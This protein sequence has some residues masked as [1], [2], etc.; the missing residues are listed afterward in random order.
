MPTPPLRFDR[1]ARHAAALVGVGFAA[2][3]SI[4]SDFSEVVQA[5]N[6]AQPLPDDVPLL[7]FVQFATLLAF[8]LISFA[9][10]ATTPVR[11]AVT[12]TV[13][14]LLLLGWAFLGIERSSGVLPLGD[15]RI[16]GVLLDQGFVT[17]AVALAG[18]LIAR[19]MHPATWPILLLAVLPPLARVG[20]TAAQADSVSLALALQAVTLLSVLVGAA[21]AVRLDRA[22]RRTPPPVTLRRSTRYG[23]AVGAIVVATYL[24]VA[25]DFTAYVQSER[26]AT[27]ASAALLGV[28][29]LLLVLGMY[30]VA[31]LVMPV[32][33]DRRLA[34]VTV[35]CVV[36]LLWATL[37]IERGAGNIGPPAAFWSFV[38][39]QG[40]VTLLVTLGGWL[41][42][43]GRHPAAFVV[44][45]L[46]VVPPLVA[47]ALADSA[48][49]SG[50]YALILDAV[51]S[52][53][54]AVGA[55]AAWGV[56]AVIR[57][58][59]LGGS[60]ATEAAR[61]P[62]A[63]RTR[64]RPRTVT[65]VA[66]LVWLSGS[67]QILTGML[68]LAGEG[69]AGEERRTIALI[70]AVLSILIGVGTVVVG[71]ALLEGRRAARVILTVF[72]SISAAGSLIGVVAAAVGG[73]PEEAVGSALTAAVDAVPLILVWTG[74]GR[75][76]F[77]RRESAASDIDGGR[78]LVTTKGAA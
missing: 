12:L 24:G 21:I 20:L 1:D 53:G 65:I 23:I 40:F 62:R 30:L 9:L 74:G 46:A 16:W 48:V 41:L 49:P 18:W 37:G 77:G 13:V 22:I 38:L 42:V 8:Y 7:E 70:G 39:N 25:S 47:R 59:R 44:V 27:G 52:L 3:L 10:I 71:A 68:D 76:Y 14:P 67:I 31:F 28:V 73:H 57:R 54:A 55:L 58:I 78:S 19:R 56:D 4:S 35:A 50:A 17:V 6:Y 72:V 66:V 45:A 51:T 36:L 63:V 64:V 43:R 29:Q 33:S 34:A 15:S 26:Y 2:F 32:G 75:R 5:V 61:A 69:V 60:T 11:R